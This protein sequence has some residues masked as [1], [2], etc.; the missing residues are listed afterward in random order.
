MA[1]LTTPRAQPAAV[2]R[3]R[4]RWRIVGLALIAATI[5]LCGWFVQSRTRESATHKL[6]EL[7]P[8]GA[9]Y[10]LFNAISLEGWQIRSGEWIP[11]DDPEIS[12][13]DGVIAYRMVRQIKGGG[14]EAIALFELSLLIQRGTA[15]AAELHF[16]LEAG[17]DDGERHVVQIG[18][19]AMSIGT[20]PADREPFVEKQ[21]VSLKSLD[22]RAPHSLS[23]ECQSRIWVVLYGDEVVFTVPRRSAGELPE[24][25]LGVFGQKSLFSDIELQ[26]L[27][28][29]D[30][31]AQ[32]SQ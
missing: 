13:A 18:K 22:D 3:R 12:G 4:S 32:S 27:Q 31:P 24:F 10:Y 2:P 5:G 7:E 21:R 25:R 20:R 19:D 8:V 23:L 16:G 30:K 29:P 17:K 26:E 1:Q 14:K 28:E 11:T 15:T 9:R 6:P